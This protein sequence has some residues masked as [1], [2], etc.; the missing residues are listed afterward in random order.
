VQCLEAGL[1]LLPES[2]LRS[3]I[4]RGL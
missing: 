2:E 1:R 3:A 4:K